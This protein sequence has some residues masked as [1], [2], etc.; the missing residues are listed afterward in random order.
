VL[1]N[2]FLKNDEFSVDSIIKNISKTLDAPAS[3]L[4]RHNSSIQLP[5]E[6]TA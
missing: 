4:P 3:S 6:L 1:P 5:S 2:E